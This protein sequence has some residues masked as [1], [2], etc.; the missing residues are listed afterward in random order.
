MESVIFPRNVEHMAK[1]TVQ[2][3]TIFQP[4]DRA[5]IGCNKILENTLSL[6]IDLNITGWESVSCNICGR[7]ADY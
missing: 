6:F 2:P 7:N 5:R 3:K 1:L 4:M